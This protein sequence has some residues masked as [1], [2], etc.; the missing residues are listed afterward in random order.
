LN[1]SGEGRVS[2]SLVELSRLAA[3][4]A[5]T[6][7][8]QIAEAGKLVWDSLSAGGK[9]LACGNG[10]SAADAQH[11]VA[12]L[13]GRMGRERRALPAVSLSA[14]SSVVTALTNDYGAENLFS[15]QIEALGQTG[16]VLLAISTSG[17]SPNVLRAVEVAHQR[18][19]RTIAL[20]G[21]DGDPSLSSCDVC[22]HV[23]CPNSQR[24]QELH[25]AALHAICDLVERQVTAGLLESD[26]ALP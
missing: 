4:V 23:P 11:F 17:H 5:D 26:Q 3:T 24:V 13:V 25:M 12:E 15:R 8:E 19:L 20:L 16:D 22:I 18:G 7:A 9:V 1:H 10:G 21:E 14:D 6:A 2:E